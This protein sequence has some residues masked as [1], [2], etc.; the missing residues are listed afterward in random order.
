MSSLMRSRGG[1]G[2]GGGSGA[3]KEASEEASTVILDETQQ[4]AMV[5][6][7]EAQAT[8]HAAVWRAVFGGGSVVIG[9][10]FLWLAAMV[11][12]S[13]PDATDV[14]TGVRVR[15]RA[16]RDSKRD[17]SSLLYDNNLTSRHAFLHALC[18]TPDA[19]AQLA[20]QRG[21]KGHTAVTTIHARVTSS[22]SPN[23]PLPL[24][25]STRNA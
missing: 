6:E 5:R 15:V 3:E 21:T 7:L 17:L 25:F 16:R 24:F 4:E 20:H 10:Y 13:Q 12:S 22:T 18:P 8:R 9:L 19:D 11:A 1:G 14:W 2:G 23:P